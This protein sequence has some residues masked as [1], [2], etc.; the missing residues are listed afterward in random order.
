MHASYDMR[1]LPWRGEQQ[2]LACGRLNLPEAGQ[3]QEFK[4]KIEQIR[5]SK[6]TPAMSQP[7]GGIGCG[8]GSAFAPWAA[9][10]LAAL[11]RIP[12]SLPSSVRCRQWMPVQPSLPLL[13]ANSNV[14]LLQATGSLSNTTS[15]M[16]S[17]HRRKHHACT[18]KALVGR[19]LT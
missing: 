15:S 1:H 13:V 10:G 19:A 2:V 3:Q 8:G 17:P 4:D 14:L 6:L 11:S 12:S 9:E 16:P 18:C 5:K 7:G